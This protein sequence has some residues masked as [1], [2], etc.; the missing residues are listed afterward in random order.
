MTVVQYEQPPPLPASRPGDELER[1]PVGDVARLRAAAEYAHYIGNTEF[2]PD[3]MRGR[4]EAITA[5][6]LAGEELGLQKMAS[7]R[8]IVIIRGRPAV[9]AEALR[10]LVNAAGH[11]IWFEETTTTRCIAAGRRGGSDRVGRITWTMDDA[12]RAGLAGQ[13][14]YRTYPAEMLRARA[15]AALARAMFADV[16]L[17]LPAVEEIDEYGADGQIVEVASQPPPADAEPQPPAGRTRRRRPASNPSASAAAPATTPAREGIVTR[18]VLGPEQTSSFLERE[19]VRPEPPPDTQEPPPAAEPPATDAQK[20][21][22]FALMRDSGLTGATDTDR[23]HRLGY[24]SRIIGRRIQ[25]SNELTIREAG[26]V[27]DDLQEIAKLPADERADRLAPADATALIDELKREL[28]AVE[29]TAEPRAT[30]N[31][32]AQRDRLRELFFEKKVTDPEER[33]VYS[34]GVLGR[35]PDSLDELTE[36]ETSTLIAHLQQYDPDDP[37]TRPL[38]AGF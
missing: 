26:L 15:S 7:L 23:E 18:E 21:Q 19:P 17:G 27:I 35:R 33:L 32:P 22:I 3:G 34:A 25:S 6:L 14:S 20:R 11:E 1:G 29:V 10:A 2:V 9:Y 16:T 4:S 13:Q 38:P 37:Q 8:S 12:K 30:D 28:D 36:D 24:T 31:E 5:A